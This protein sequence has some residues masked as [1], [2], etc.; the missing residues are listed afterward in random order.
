MNDITYV[1][2]DQALLDMAGFGYSVMDLALQMARNYASI[3]SG[4]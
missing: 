1:F 3:G 4:I 2:P